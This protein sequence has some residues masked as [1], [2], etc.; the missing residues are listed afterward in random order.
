MNWI[1]TGSLD[2]VLQVT[3]YTGVITQTVASSGS[4]TFIPPLGNS[5]HYLYTENDVGPYVSSV[6]VA[7]NNFPPVFY[8]VTFT[9]TEDDTS[10][11][12]TLS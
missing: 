12:G 2:N 11:I 5:T 8:P 9:G 6:G 1:V 7:T 3:T 10:I 4:F